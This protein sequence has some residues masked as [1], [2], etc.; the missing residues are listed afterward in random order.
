[1]TYSHSLKVARQSQQ[2]ACLPT[3]IAVRPTCWTKL[4]SLSGIKHILYK[5]LVFNCHIKKGTYSWNTQVYIKSHKLFVNW[6]S[7]SH[8][9]HVWKYITSHSVQCTSTHSHPDTGDMLLFIVL[10]ICWFVLR[11]VNCVWQSQSFGYWN[12]FKYLWKKFWIVFKK[13][14]KIW[15][16]FNTNSTKILKFSATVN[17]YLST[18][19]M[20]TFEVHLLS[21]DFVHPTS[22][23][24]DTVE[25][26]VLIKSVP[27]YRGDKHDKRQ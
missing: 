6:I 23:C 2:V 21:L 11:L 3:S 22:A 24:Q 12:I 8:F 15:Y 13:N 26:H 16:Y 10:I 17:T 5:N 1:M 4:L 14:E 25:I 19:Q 27:P 9:D 18:Y 7:F 20:L